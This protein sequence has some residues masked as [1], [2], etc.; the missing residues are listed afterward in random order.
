MA[1]ASGARKR[2]VQLRL[3]DGSIIGSQQS[4]LGTEGPAIVLLDYEQAART[5]RAGEAD[6]ARLDKLIS[7]FQSRIAGFHSIPRNELRSRNPYD[8]RRLRTCMV[9]M[10]PNHALCI[11]CFKGVK[12]RQ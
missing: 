9:A 3:D 7:A 6:L 10:P 2:R 8:V 4:L 5:G 12:P 1:A 11:G